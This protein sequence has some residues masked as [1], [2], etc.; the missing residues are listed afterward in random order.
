MPLPTS[1]L[2]LLLLLLVHLSSPLTGVA[3][4]LPKEELYA[5]CAVFA[6]DVYN[7]TP[8]DVPAP[9]PGWRHVGAYRFH[10]MKSG[11][12]DGYAD[13]Y[14]SDQHD[15][16]IAIR[17]SLSVNP[18]Y[19]YKREPFGGLIPNPLAEDADQHTHNRVQ[20]LVWHKTLRYAASHNVLKGE[21]TRAQLLSD[22]R[23]MCQRKFRIAFTGHGYGGA[24]ATFL[25][26][27]VFRCT[28]TNE[29]A[30]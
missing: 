10:L 16:I 30:G 22:A 11:K 18:D 4:A 27:F 12:H 28:C 8:L 2:A 13:A 23:H 5:S 26:W 25:A 29:I 17:G 21:F 14:R 9:L 20:G 7:E 1:A 6:G 3:A 19:S 24:V 15:Y